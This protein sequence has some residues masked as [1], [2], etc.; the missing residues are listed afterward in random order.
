MKNAFSGLISRRGMAEERIS[1][2]EDV[3]VE[4]FKTEKQREQRLKKK[5]NPTTRREY[6][7]SMGEL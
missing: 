6:P 7:R 1:E 2:L 3:S 4:T 5:T